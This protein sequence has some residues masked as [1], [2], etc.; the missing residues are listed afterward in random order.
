M[1]SISEK[2]LIIIPDTNICD[3]LYPETK[4]EFNL[5]RSRN[6]YTQKQIDDHVSKIRPTRRKYYVK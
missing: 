1:K 5:H 4:K 2:P 3:L 6:L